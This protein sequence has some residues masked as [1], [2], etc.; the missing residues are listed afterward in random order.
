VLAASHTGRAPSACRHCSA[1]FQF[2]RRRGD[3]EL[4]VAEDADALR[5]DGPQALGIGRRLRR[6]RSERGERRSN[7]R[8]KAQVAALRFCRQ[9]GVDQRQ[10]H[11][12]L[13]GGGDQVGPQLGFHEQAEARLEVVEKT[14]AGVGQ[15]VGKIGL[16]QAIAVFRDQSRRR[17]RG[18]SASCA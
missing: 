6:H 7:E 1:E 13:R 2:L 11:A 16:Q 5:A 4:D 9:A 12:A 8:R 3:V 15:V 10:R 18:R 14:A 17:S